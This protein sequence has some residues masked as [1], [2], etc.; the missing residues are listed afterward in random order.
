MYFLISSTQ[1]G[2][3]CL[4]V[5][6]IC[7]K[8]IDL[9]NSIIFR[10]LSV[11]S[12]GVVFFSLIFVLLIPVRVLLPDAVMLCALGLLPTLKIGVDRRISGP[13]LFRH[14]QSRHR[15]GHGPVAEARPDIGA[16]RHLAPRGRMPKLGGALPQ[17]VQKLIVRVVFMLRRPRSVSFGQGLGL[18]LPLRSRRTLPRL[19]F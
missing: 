19:G 8:S 5:M 14:R 4:I 16:T 11:T 18:C 9:A 1:I 13:L 10:S 6:S 2:E 12:I 17:I 3:P 7:P 15:Q